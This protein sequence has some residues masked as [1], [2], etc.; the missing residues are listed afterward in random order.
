MILVDTSVWVEYLQRDKELLE[1]LI[2]VDEVLVHPFVIGEVSCGH[3]P[4][5]ARVMEEL[6][7]LPR[8]LIAS[9]SDVL[10]FLVQHSLMGTGVNYIDVHLLTVAA[11][12]KIPL[13]TFDRKLRAA[14]LALD[15]AADAFLEELEIPA[16]AGHPL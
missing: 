7:D 4:D 6:H 12:R 1:H 11:S 2:L 16:P 13:W 9:E 14:A 15:L 5:R 8:S 10:D 3:L